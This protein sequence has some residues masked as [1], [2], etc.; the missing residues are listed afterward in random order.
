MDLLEIRD[1]VDHD[2]RKAVVSS[3]ILCNRSRL[4]DE[5][6]RK[7]AAFAD[8][9]YIPFYYHLGKC[10]TPKTLFRYGFGIGLFLGSFLQGCHSVERVFAFREGAVEDWSAARLGGK[11]LR[12]VYKRG[13]EIYVGSLSDQPVQ[14]RLTLGWDMILVETEMAYDDLRYLLDVLWRHVNRDG[15]MVVERADEGNVAHAP[16]QDFCKI[17]RLDPLVFSTRYGTGVVCK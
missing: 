11:N 9:T 16:F 4:L 5:G 1:K 12:D 15:Y 3:R 2:M 17:N 8:D 6:S 7:S 13:L 14:E 10:I